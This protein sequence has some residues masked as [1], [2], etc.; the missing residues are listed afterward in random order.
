MADYP[1]DVEVES[2]YGTLRVTDKARIREFSINGGTM[3]ATFVKNPFKTVGGWRYIDCFEIPFLLNPDI[4][5]VL[6]MGL[7]TG[8]L[9]R[10]IYHKYDVK[11]DTVEIDAKV[12][13]LSKRYFDI[14]TSDDF[15]IFIDDARVF[16]KGSEDKY[17]FIAIDI[18]KHDPA[19]GYKIPFHIATEEFFT[20]VQEH[21]NPG[22]IV[23][24]NYATS[25]DSGFF[26][27]EYKTLGSVFDSTYAFHCSTQMIMAHDGNAQSIDELKQDAGEMAQFLEGHYEPTLTQDT[28]VLTDEY[29]P[30]DLFSELV[31]EI[32]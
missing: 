4:K 14:R 12:V 6:A 20:I 13:G 23:M 7:A 5:H 16:L 9:Q 31:S 26:Q 2:L 24:M 8:N 22:G 15:R 18:F 28:Q 27:S 21:L 3:G 29:F 1:V 19:E 30:V 32:S 10:N 17:D 25:K 11:V